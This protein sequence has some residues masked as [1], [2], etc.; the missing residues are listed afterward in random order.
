M[1]PDLFLPYDR[2]E[3]ARTLPLQ[4]AQDR[5]VSQEAHRNELKLAYVRSP[6]L[7]FP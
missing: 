1:W 7:Q 6:C 5:V 4:A 2:A 3:M